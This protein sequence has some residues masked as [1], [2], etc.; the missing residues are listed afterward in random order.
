MLEKM[1]TNNKRPVARTFNASVDHQDYQT[2]VRYRQ[3]LTT[4]S[5]IMDF[6]ADEFSSQFSLAFC[7][8]TLAI[9]SLDNDTGVSPIEGRLEYKSFWSLAGR[10][11]TRWLRYGSFCIFS[12]GS[13][14]VRSWCTPGGWYPIKWQ[15]VFLCH[16]SDL[17]AFHK[18]KKHCK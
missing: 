9:W 13:A 5:S 1:V 18:C 7:A 4:E 17:Y 12:G 11:A 3:P 10:L 6:P 2:R 15:W 14:G 16:A 8:L